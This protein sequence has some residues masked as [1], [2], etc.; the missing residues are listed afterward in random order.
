MSEPLSLNNLSAL[1]AILPLL[2]AAANFRRLS[3][4]LRIAAA[5]FLVAGLFELIL[6]LT[7]A[8][9]M[10]NNMPL[11]HLFIFISVSSFCIIYY[12]AL[13]TRSLKIIVIVLGPLALVLVSLNAFLLQGIWQ[14]PSF[15]NTVQC[16]LMITFSLLY[17]YH[18]FIRQEYVHIEKQALFWINSG[19]L[20]YFSLNIFLFMLFNL[21]VAQ[22]RN[23]LYA[24]HSVTNIISN[25]LYAIGLL[26]KPQK[27]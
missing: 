7:I 1:S 3:G 21:V 15:S 8:A 17:F 26:C 20:I 18:I 24:I 22:Q 11:L 12:R 10:P 13:N 25:I 2:A 6:L 4:L 23:D 16:I 19:V 5:Y 9:G 27:T 14:Y